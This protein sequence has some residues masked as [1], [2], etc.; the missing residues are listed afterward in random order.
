MTLAESIADPP[1]SPMTI[2][3]PDALAAANASSIVLARS[4]D[5]V[6][7]FGSTPSKSSTRRPAAVRRS[8]TRP[9]TPE[10][11]TP[12]SVTT[13]TARPP[14]LP[15][16]AGSSTMPAPNRARSRARISSRRPA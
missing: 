1:P 8:T 16:I 11:T 10:P 6:P 4:I 15:T 3:P 9:A 7:G 14:R 12:E 5:D 2:V 13:N